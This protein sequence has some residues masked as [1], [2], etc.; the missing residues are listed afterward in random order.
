MTSYDTWDS[1]FWPDAPGV[2][3]NKFGIKNYPDL[4]VAEAHAVAPRMRGIILDSPS[5]LP[6]TVDLDY[7]RQVHHRLFQDVYSWAGTTRVVPQ[8]A[9]AK[10]WRDVVNFAPDDRTAPWVTYRYAP[11]RDVEERATAVFSNLEH[12]LSDPKCHA[13]QTFIPTVAQHWGQLDQVHPFREGNTRSQTMLMAIV[14]RK[15]GYALDGVQLLAR[16]EEFI[17]ARY[18]GHGTGHYGRLTALLLDTVGPRASEQVTDQERHW[19][20]S[21]TATTPPRRPPS[22]DLGR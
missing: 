13:P 6:E 1:Y 11:G 9:M 4:A 18:H 17:G 19:A 15:Y 20:E 21:L 16:R 22:H 3:K 12:A 7:Y 8:G 2:L 14:C 5:T 10:Q